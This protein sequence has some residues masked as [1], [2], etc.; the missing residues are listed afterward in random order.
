MRFLRVSV[1]ALMV[2]AMVAGS[3]LAADPTTDT[4]GQE[5]TNTSAG[6]TDSGSTTG[7]ETVDDAVYNDDSDT[8]GDEVYEE[9]LTVIDALYEAK[10]S[11]EVLSI[12]PPEGDQPGTIT[13]LVAGKEV[14]LTFTA[15]MLEGDV[16][17]GSYVELKGTT[18]SLEKIDVSDEDDASSEFKT[19]VVGVTPATEEGGSATIT[20]MIGGQEL[21]F[22]AEELG[23]P[24]DALDLVTV[25]AEFKLET[26]ED[27]TTEMKISSESGEIKVEVKEDGTVEVKAE[28]EGE[29][30]GKGHEISE[31]KKAEAE[32]HKEEAKA[33]AKAE[34][35]KEKG[36]KKA[37][38]ARSKGRR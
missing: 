25:G 21:T 35:A 23:I 6:T 1:A 27:G 17:E 16:A 7:S 22:S 2:L 15:D 5:T 3:A 10:L 29:K 31:E 12:T 24:A 11:G 4:S 20:L 13:L 37:E 26:N 28:T 34:A 14:T 19:A 8:V 18:Q 38:A 30:H 32:K 36:Q 9:P 33:K